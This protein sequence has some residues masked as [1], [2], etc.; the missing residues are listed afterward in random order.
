MPRTFHVDLAHVVCFSDTHSALCETAPSLWQ[1][2]MGGSGWLTAAALVA[3]ED[4]AAVCSSLGSDPWGQSLWRQ[5]ADAN[6]DLRYLQQQVRRPSLLSCHPLQGEA[7]LHAPDACAELHLRPDNLPSGWQSA[8]RWAV[9]GGLVF[10][11]GDAALRHCELAQRLKAQGKRIAYLP[12]WHDSFDVGFDATLSAMVELADAV[13]VTD[14]QLCNLMRTPDPLSALGQISHW[15]P[16]AEVLRIQAAAHATLYRGLD[17]WHQQR[18]GEP[19]HRHTVALMTAG[20]LHA[21]LMG[22]SGERALS[23]ALAVAAQGPPT[24]HRWR[25]RVLEAL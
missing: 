9:F 2:E 11:D 21:S 24:D 6:L 13:I 5:C 20:W 18:E 16:K 25:Q 19:T 14:S 1:W 15:N 22:E 23:W 3:L 4:L 17:D 8:L 10:A 7:W 12:G